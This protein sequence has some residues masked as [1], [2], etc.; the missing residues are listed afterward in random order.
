M[1]KIKPGTILPTDK[2]DKEISRQAKKDGTF[3]TDEQLKKM[4]PASSF[5]ELET[6]ATRGRPRKKNPKQQVTIRLDPEI[7]NFFKTQGAGWQTA[8]HAVLEEHVKDRK[9]N[10]SC[11]K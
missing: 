3:F 7:L 5:P 4:Q 2:E 9:K 10:G 11:L 8:I 1:P 6:L